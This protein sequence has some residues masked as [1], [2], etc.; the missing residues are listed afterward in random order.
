MSPMKK[1]LFA[2]LLSMPMSMHSSFAADAGNV[3]QN[4]TEICAKEA[5]GKSTEERYEYM[6]SCVQDKAIQE[7][8]SGTQEAQQAKAKACKTEAEGMKG[9]D[10]KKHIKQCQKKK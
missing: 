5:S 4:K 9:N 1:L 10:K 6:R 2:I 7:K 8:P 3:Q